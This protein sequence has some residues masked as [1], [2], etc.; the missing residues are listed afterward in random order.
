MIEHP[1]VPVVEL[2]TIKAS[3]AFG[4]GS[5]PGG[6]T[7]KRQTFGRSAV[8][9]AAPF[10]AVPRKM[11]DCDAAKAP[12]AWNIPPRAKIIVMEKN[13]RLTIRHKKCILY[14][15]RRRKGGTRREYQ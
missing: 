12:A 2:D 15:Y 11:S 13:Y 6:H 9:I 3:D 5:S 14:M 7:N 10:S 4:P 8:C 1:H